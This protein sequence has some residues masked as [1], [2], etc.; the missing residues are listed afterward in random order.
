MECSTCN[1]VEKRTASA[2]LAKITSIMSVETQRNVNLSQ[3]RQESVQSDND[4]IELLCRVEPSIIARCY[5]SCLLCLTND[6]LGQ[7]VKA[8]CRLILKECIYPTAL[9][10]TRVLFFFAAHT[11][12]KFG[13]LIM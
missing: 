12:D 5:F 1:Y 8:R 7:I 9:C 13:S 10:S 3:R 2:P 6:F 11:F 4:R